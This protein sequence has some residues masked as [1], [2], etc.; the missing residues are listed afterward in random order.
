MITI[1]K[2]ID[3]DKELWN[4]F[5]LKSKNSLFMFNRDYMDYHRDRFNDH[6]L[7]FF[8][9]NE[10][11]AILPLSERN[12]TFSSHGG[13]T[14]GGFISN[15]HMKQ[16]TM[17]LCFECLKRYCI[18]NNI[19]RII[20]KTIPHIYHMQPAEEDRYALYYF[21]AQILK[22]EAST[23]VNLK[24][25]I[26][27]AKLRIRQIKKA[28]KNGVKVSIQDAYE[29]YD[30]YISL[31]NLVLNE[32]HNVN[33]VHTAK[34]IFLLHMRFPENIRLYVATHEGDIVAGTIIYIYDTVVHT[35]YLASNDIGRNIG[36]LD[37]VIKTVIDDYGTN[38]KYIDFG[39][40][41]EEMG[42]VLNYG[43]ISQK[44]GFGG[45]TLIY[46]TWEIIVE[47]D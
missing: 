1:R 25:A 31:L 16:N 9:N 37:L 32:H 23:V 30:K 11:I 3:D 15:L 36:A 29:A 7:L 20:Y 12:G 47:E 24:D 14:Y 46:E 2:F 21:N 40:S 44:E 4:E 26:P 13:L 43:L 22:V 18:Q 6:S 35:Q 41:T 38:K 19:D 39:I 27:M 10:L 45:R 8:E 5:N 34:E 17:L 28:I 42:R 33:A